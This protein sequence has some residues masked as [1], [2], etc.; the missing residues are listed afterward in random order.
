MERKKTTAPSKKVAKKPKSSS[1]VISYP[2]GMKDV[3]ANDYKF[4]DP[5]LKKIDE[6]A[7]NYSFT[8]INTPIFENLA[9]YRKFFDKDRLK[10]LFVSEVSTTEK[11][12]LRFDLIHGLIRSLEQHS[13][14]NNLEKPLKFFSVGPVFRQ[15]KIRSGTYRQ[16]NQFNFSIVNDPKPVSDAFLIYLVYNIFKE[17]QI[18]VQIQVNTLGDDACQKDFLNH[19]SRFL[20]ERGQ[21]TKLCNECKKN[22]LKNPKL[23]LECNEKSCLELRSEA[24]QI[25]DFLSEESHSRFY[26]TIEFLDEL[27]VNYNFN[28]S[29][30]KDLSYYNDLIF[31]VW[32]FD[33]NGKTNPYLALGRGGHYDK[34]LSKVSGKNISFLGFSGGLER[35]LIKTR[36][37][38]LFIDDSKDIIFLAQLDVSAK[39]KS[40]FLFKELLSK[41]YNVRQAFHLDA[42]KAQLEE[43]KSHKAKIILI[44]GKKELSEETIL[45]RDTESGVQEIIAQKDLISR[46]EKFLSQEGSLK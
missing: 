27:E 40:M 37:N 41:G 4:L 39:A 29:L 25:V 13:V 28:P 2:L 44:L 5:V 31:E 35:T 11:L 14:F 45:F 26:K 38:N 30:I 3:L 16:F 21:K 42:L 8:K 46:L 15:E 43:A 7:R 23:I 10:S 6:T 34:A 12:A 33:K 32:P 24:P 18:D 19:F 36:E 22:L 9:L 1:K 17:L 20:K